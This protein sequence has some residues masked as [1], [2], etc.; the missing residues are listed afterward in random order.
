MDDSQRAR[1]TAML[2][3][4]LAM[5]LM[6]VVTMLAGPE[7][8]PIPLAGVGLVFVAVGSRDRRTADH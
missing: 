1:G 3:V 6:A 4:G 2:V 7:S 8:L 5:V